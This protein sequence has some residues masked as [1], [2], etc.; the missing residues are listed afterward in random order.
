MY[1]SVIL[2]LL[3]QEDGKDNLLSSTPSIIS[4]FRDYNVTGTLNISV[5]YFLDDKLYGSADPNNPPDF[6]HIVWGWD[7]QGYSHEYLKKSG[8]CQA[9]GVGY[10][11]TH[12][13]SSSSDKSAEISMGLFFHT[14]I[15]Y[16]HHASHLDT[17]LDCHVDP[18]AIYID[19]KRPQDRIR[20]T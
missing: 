1:S 8:T 18:R 9:S 20:D 7:S 16:E 19:E 13:L 2:H 6:Q 10:S 15:L 12:L 17:W 11:C 3:T 14:I 4:K 5:A